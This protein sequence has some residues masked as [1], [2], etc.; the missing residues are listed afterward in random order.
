MLKSVQL[1]QS[2]WNI[3]IF[4]RQREKANRTPVKQ[5]KKHLMKTYLTAGMYHN[6]T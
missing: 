4:E 3:Y 5:L 6:L 2:I 1:Y